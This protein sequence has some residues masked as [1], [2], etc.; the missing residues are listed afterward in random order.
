MSHVRVKAKLIVDLNVYFA[1]A[2]T[3]QSCN[4]NREYRQSYLRNCFVRL[5][6]HHFELATTANQF[7][8]M[9]KKRC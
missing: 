6:F 7:V 9:D 1:S 8:D 2:Q 3:L 4:I 5:C